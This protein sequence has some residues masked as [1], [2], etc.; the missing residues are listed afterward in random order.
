MGLLFI[1]NMLI[2]IVITFLIEITR[3]DNI[4][5][6]ELKNGHFEK[7]VHAA[8]R[9]NERACRKR[10][11]EKL[12]AKIHLTS[13]AIQRWEKKENEA[14]SPVNEIVLRAFFN[15]QFQF[16][17]PLHFTRFIYIYIDKSIFLRYYS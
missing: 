9:M 10:I 16:P 12:A 3:I 11:L 7:T 14:I 13:K 5:I 1:F 2:V 8:T 17:M 15:D 4:F 6:E